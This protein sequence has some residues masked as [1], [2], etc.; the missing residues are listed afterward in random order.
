MIL[1]FLLCLD[2][3]GF[4]NIIM[5]M[6]SFHVAIEDEE[7]SCEEGEYE[8]EEDVLEEELE[9]LSRT[10]LLLFDEEVIL[11]VA[12]VAEDALVQNNASRHTVGMHFIRLFGVSLH[13]VTWNYP[14][15]RYLQILQVICL[16]LQALLHF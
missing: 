14:F 1:L 8:H 15:R 11:E 3:L 12:F 16:L 13:T 7:S 10:Y 6:H 5:R 4:F 2:L 9:K